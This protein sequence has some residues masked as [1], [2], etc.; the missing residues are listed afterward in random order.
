MTLITALELTTHYPDQIL[1][2]HPEENGKFGVFV[3]MLRG[4]HIHKLML[5]TDNRFPF[6]SKKEAAEWIK[7]VIEEGINHVKNL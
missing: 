5:S 4:K 3:Y 2:D 7:K 1:I 6:D